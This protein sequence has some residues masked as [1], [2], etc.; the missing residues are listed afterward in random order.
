MQTIQTAA[1]REATPSGIDSGGHA[2]HRQVLRSGTLTR[3]VEATMRHA[4]Y[5]Q[6]AAGQP[7]QG[8]ITGLPSLCAEATTR[9]AC[10]TELR[11]VLETWLRVRLCQQ[12][13]IP[14][15]DGIPLAAWVWIK[16]GF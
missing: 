7:Y 4:T 14:P 5:D 12:L 9:D 3:Y 6:A 15:M 2:M 11:D 1:E 10:R 16:Q 13:P 8:Q